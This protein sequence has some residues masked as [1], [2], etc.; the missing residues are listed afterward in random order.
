MRCHMNLGKCCTLSIGSP[1]GR[2]P[3]PSLRNRDSVLDIEWTL[4]RVPVSEK[5]F[6]G[7]IRGT[8]VVAHEIE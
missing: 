7:A 8:Y 2:L 5:S 3:R 1:K 6:H 4:W